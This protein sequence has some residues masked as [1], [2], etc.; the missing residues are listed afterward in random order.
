[1]TDVI[2][3]GY[4]IKLSQR[5]L[6]KPRFFRVKSD[7]YCFG[8]K[9]EYIPKGVALLSQSGSLPTVTECPS[10]A[11]YAIELR[12][13]TGCFFRSEDNC[14]M[15][16][17]KSAIQ[18]A[19][20]STTGTPRK[21][22]G[23][24]ESNGLLN[25][26]PEYS[27]RPEIKV[28]F[29]LRRGF[30]S[31]WKRYW[32]VVREGILQYYLNDQ[33][34]TP[35]GSMEL[36]MDS[37]VSPDCP[38]VYVPYL[39]QALLHVSAIKSLYLIAE[40]RDDQLEWIMAINAAIE[41]QESEK[42][43]IRKN[44]VGWKRTGKVKE[45]ITPFIDLLRDPFRV[46]YFRSFMKDTGCTQY[47]LFWLDVQQFKRLCKKEDRFYLKPCASV[48][49]TKYLKEGGAYYVGLPSEVADKTLPLIDEPNINTFRDTQFEIY[50]T[51]RDDFYPIFLTSGHC[52]AMAAALF[53]TIYLA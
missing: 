21:P 12:Y 24:L 40:S 16:D 25:N 27:S 13:T 47:L 38:N 45:V 51:L 48:I 22:F 19:I 49:Y 46:E 32:V 6:H 41:L 18:K 29:L 33:A 15:A 10:L 37:S 7:L 44:P 9:D 31:E 36:V 17:W 42:V 34:M 52:H 43:A 8:T 4:L 20:K 3:E 35:K 53:S 23:S 30:G 39:N 2:K 5:G 26:A 14:N 11:P 28:G 50:R 1:M